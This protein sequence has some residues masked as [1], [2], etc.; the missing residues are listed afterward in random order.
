MHS[1]VASTPCNAF[2]SLTF[3]VLSSF[4]HISACNVLRILLI[5]TTYCFLVYFIYLIYV[6]V[7]KYFYLLLY[8]FV[9]KRFGFSFE[10]RGSKVPVDIII[11]IKMISGAPETGK[12]TL[13]SP[14]D[15]YNYM[16]ICA[17][18]I[19]HLHRCQQFKLV[20]DPGY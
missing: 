10:A 5:F 13:R 1:F 18:P 16:I 6:I 15:K 7:L 9:V 8:R 2:R 20:E 19:M 11:I 12:S 14:L 17:Y 3:V 4:W